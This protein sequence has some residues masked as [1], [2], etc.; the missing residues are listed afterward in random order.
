[1]T[2]SAGVIYELVDPRDGSCRYVG[3]TFDVEQRRKAHTAP[4]PNYQGNTELHR[5]KKGLANAGLAPEFRV[6]EEGIPPEEI[7][8]QESFWCRRRSD[9][10]SDLLNCHV[11]AIKRNDLLNATVR[12][13]WAMSA[14]EIREMLQSVS[15][16]V[17]GKLPSGSRA[18]RKLNKSISE[19]LGFIHAIDD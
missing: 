18:C 19:L 10:G 16:Q 9:E 8:R 4:K 13:S 7:N 14:R 6:I 15:A 1:M 5:W 17:N 12:H 2:R 3:Q 11:G